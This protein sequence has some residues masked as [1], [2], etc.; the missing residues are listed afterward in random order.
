MSNWKGIIK[1]SPEVKDRIS[2]SKGKFTPRR[3]PNSSQDHSF[4]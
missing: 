3:D 4:I 2:K 1:N